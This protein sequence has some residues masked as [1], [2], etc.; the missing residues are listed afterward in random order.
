VKSA[1]VFPNT[2]AIKELLIRGA[3]RSIREKG[4]QKTRPD[5]TKPLGLRPYDLVHDLKDEEM[6]K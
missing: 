5:G 6:K 4:P 1:E 3:S 2:R